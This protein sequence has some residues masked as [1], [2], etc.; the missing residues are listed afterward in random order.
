MKITLQNK[1]YNIILGAIGTVAAIVFCIIAVIQTPFLE[2]RI[3]GLAITIL[4]LVYLWLIILRTW[5]GPFSRGLLAAHSIFLG[6]M[7]NCLVWSI[8]N[9]I[10]TGLISATMGMIIAFITTETI[11]VLRFL[12]QSDCEF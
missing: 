8:S 3:W 10:S 4:E 12:K 7:I 9:W 6:A 1:T 2:K 5:S 11:H